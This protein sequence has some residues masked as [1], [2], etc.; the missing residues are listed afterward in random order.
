MRIRVIAQP[1]DEFKAWE[2]Q[3]LQTPTLT[4]E[5]AVGEQLF[6]SMACVNCHVENPIGP[7][8]TH[9]GSRETIGTGVLDNTPDNLAKWLRNPQAVK[10]GVHMPN[11]N[12]T[13]AEINAL[14]AYLE[15]SK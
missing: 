1:Q 8:L 13:D 6:M 4:G 15:A 3:Q 10:P 12:L 14:V 5:A 2:Q 7:D 11:L 9:F